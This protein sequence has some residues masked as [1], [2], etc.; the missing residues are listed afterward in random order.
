MNVLKRPIN[1]EKMNLLGEL[2]DFKQYAFEVSMD[3]TKGQIKR[4]VEEL[5]DVKVKSIRTMVVSG[6]KRVRYTKA[7][8]IQG[9]S[10]NYKKALVTL[11]SG[12]SIDFYKNI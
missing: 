10:P 5:Y 11:D 2:P 8:Y 1:T 9:K 6:K 12:D 4:S 7:G 3:A